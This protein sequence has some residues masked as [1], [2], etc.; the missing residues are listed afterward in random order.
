MIQ[1]VLDNKV[2]TT[3]QQWKETHAQPI[4]AF[5]YD[6]QGLQEHARR[7]VSGLPQGC[8]LFYAMKANPAKEILQCLEPIVYGFEAASIGEIRKI[9]EVSAD[10]PVIFG[11]PGKKDAEIEEALEL[12]VKLI[13]AESTLELRRISLI[14][15][16]LGVQASVL[17]RVNLR[18]SFPEAT[19]VMA[20]RPTQFGIDEEQVAEAIEL[21]L[22]LPHVQLEGFHLHSISNNLDAS[23]HVRLISVYLERV[24][25]WKERFGLQLSYLNAGGGFGISYTDMERKFEWDTFT[26]GLRTVVQEQGIAGVELLFEPGRYLAAACGFYATEVVDLK[27]NHD[28]HYAILRGG[29]HHFR[30]PGAWQHSHPFEVVPVER[31]DYPFARPEIQDKEI[32][33]AGE[34]CTPKDVLARDIH[35]ARLRV[36]DIVLF[37][38]A[39]AYG[40]TISAHDF[41]SHEHPEHIFL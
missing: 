37:R 33:V 21:A 27:C 14:A 23:L 12:G 5:I 39:G 18:A 17:I 4:S 20:G 2:L 16:R 1:S 29:S 8:S 11:G 19:L 10:K 13:H 22:S 24:R 41:L 36:G 3:I 40:W 35:V 38:L 34:L 7:T 31:W 25:G 6:L 32:T 28:K 9:R 26:S 15:A 30:L